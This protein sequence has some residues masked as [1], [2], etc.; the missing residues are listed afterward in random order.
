LSRRVL[1]PILR[2]MLSDVHGT[3]YD[4]PPCAQIERELQLFKRATTRLGHEQIY[5]DK[6][7]NI[8]PCEYAEAS[9]GADAVHEK[10]EDEHE[11]ACSK[12]TTLRYEVSNVSHAAR[13]RDV[14]YK[15]T[16]TDTAI[17]ASLETSGNT[18][19]EIEKDDVP[20][21]GA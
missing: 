12:P 5:E 21:V 4:M 16:A 3:V 20:A 6:G 2:E 1:P 13:N 17:P 18:S 9:G 14:A 11:N 19:A 15:L 10:G 7:Y 8:Q